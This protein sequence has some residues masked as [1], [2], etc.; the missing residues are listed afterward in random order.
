MYFV[1][2]ALLPLILL[3]CAAFAIGGGIGLAIR[4]FNQEKKL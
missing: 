1:E 3:F 2:D 4:L